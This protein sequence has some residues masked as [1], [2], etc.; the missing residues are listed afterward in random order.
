MG[1]PNVRHYDVLLDA[2]YAAL[3]KD[4][5]LAQ[6]FY[7]SAMVTAS[8]DGFV[9]DAALATERYG[10]FLLQDLGDTKRAATQFQEAARL[11]SDWGATG[12]AEQ[13]LARNGEDLSTLRQRD[14]EAP[15]ET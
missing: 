12:V 4:F 11:Y 3:K 10:D 6:R 15:P 5:Q 9:H 7:H 2:E 1:N 14:L 13:L 8:L